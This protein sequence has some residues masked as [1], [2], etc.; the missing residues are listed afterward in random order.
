MTTNEE[1]GLTAPAADDVVNYIIMN[2]TI[3][4]GGLTVTVVRELM[5]R[6]YEQGLA[7]GSEL[8]TEVWSK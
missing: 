7:Y 6:A 2:S 3:E 5:K 1:Q 4:G 8:G